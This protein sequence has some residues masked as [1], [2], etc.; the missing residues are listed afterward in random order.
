MRPCAG[1]SPYPA[2]ILMVSIVGLVTAEDLCALNRWS[3]VGRAPGRHKQ[4]TVSFPRD[5]IV[6]NIELT[7]NLGIESD[8]RQYNNGT[9]S[10]V[11]V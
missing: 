6:S 11:T 9:E 2:P 3:F 4:R 5:H 10:T 8:R 1:C 7:V